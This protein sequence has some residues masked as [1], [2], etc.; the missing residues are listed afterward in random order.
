LAVCYE[1]GVDPKRDLQKAFNNYLKSSL[2]DD[3]KA[4]YEVGRRYTME[5]ELIKTRRSAK[6]GCCMQNRIQYIHEPGIK[7][8]KLEKLLSGNLKDIRKSG[9]IIKMTRRNIL[10]DA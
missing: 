3:K 9:L 4:F 8:I 5:L 6:W 2:L 1:K 10:Q 7:E